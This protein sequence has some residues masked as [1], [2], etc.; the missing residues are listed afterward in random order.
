MCCI[1]AWVGR[2][3]R[4]CFICAKEKQCEAENKVRKGKKMERVGVNAQEH[5]GLAAT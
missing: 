1:P 2:E 4:E 5:W 3:E